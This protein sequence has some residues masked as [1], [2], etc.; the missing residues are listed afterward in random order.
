MLKQD[1]LYDIGAW[2]FLHLAALALSEPKRDIK[3]DRVTFSELFDV[4]KLGKL[5]KAHLF[6]F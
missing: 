1:V 6:S 4:Q 2:H 3:R 5:H